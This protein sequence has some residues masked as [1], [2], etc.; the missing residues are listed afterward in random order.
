MALAFGFQSHHL[1]SPELHWLLTWR[2]ALLAE[3]R[4]CV[5]K[6]VF[7]SQLEISTETTWAGVWPIQTSSSK[8]KWPDFVL[9]SKLDCSVTKASH[10][11]CRDIQRHY[12]LHH[13]LFFVVLVFTWC[14]NNFACLCC[15]GVC[16][17]FSLSVSLL[18]FPLLLHSAIIIKFHIFKQDVYC[19]HIMIIIPHCLWIRFGFIFHIFFVRYESHLIRNIY[20]LSFVELLSGLCLY[21]Y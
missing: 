4:C 7:H 14:V 13:V 2:D 10:G 6:A 20:M 18:Y 8:S 3:G 12:K 17:C 5:V 1:A 21:I 11:W 16:R 9:K 19:F 15:W